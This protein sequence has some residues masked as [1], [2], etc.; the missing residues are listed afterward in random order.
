M[1]EGLPEHGKIV[2]FRPKPDDSPHT[3]PLGIAPPIAVGDP[4]RMALALAPTTQ[5][6]LIPAAWPQLVPDEGRDAA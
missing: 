6:A 5:E 2:T 4:Q 3:D 1:P